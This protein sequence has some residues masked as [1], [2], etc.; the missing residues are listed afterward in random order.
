MNFKT[1]KI[2][3]SEILLVN[4]CL[5]LL[6]F[7]CNPKAKET[8]VQ[9]TD[10]TKTAIVPREDSGSVDGMVWIEGGEFIMG[11]DADDV[12]PA[13]KPA[14]KN[15]VAGFWM[16]E[17]EVTNQQYKEFVD[18]TGYVTLAE[19]KPEWEDLKKQLP[20]GTPKPDDSLLQAGS[21]VFIPPAHPVPTHDISQWWAWVKGANWKHPEGP[22]SNLEGRWNHPVTHIAYED[23][24]AYAEWA[25]KRLPTEAEWEYA[26]K[27]GKYNQRYAWGDELNPNGQ[28]MANTFQ[29]I[30]PHGN[31]GRDGF[32]GTAPVKSFPANDYGLY[33]IIGNVWE[34][35]D[36]WY[37]AIKFDRIAGNAP[38]LDSGMNQCYNPNNPYAQERVIK[39]GSFLCADNYCV[40]YRPTARQGHAYDS[41]SSNV[42][43]RCVKDGDSKLL[44]SR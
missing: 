37:D 33:D 24:V 4:Y 44:S 41:G 40:N 19:K 22:N 28:F 25:G 5:A 14:V 13:E 1:L 30:F 6:L 38:K 27:A 15:K 23:A 35:T 43:F 26:A 34:M 11:T 10:E 36:D 29:G 31:E 18:A 17:T 32:M 16:D 39:G 42:G 7:S 9:K 8:D 20:P 2:N 12:Y 3:L 21:L